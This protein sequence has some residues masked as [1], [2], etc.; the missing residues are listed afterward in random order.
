MNKS[1]FKSR[2]MDIH[3]NNYNNKRYKPF[4]YYVIILAA[5]I[6]SLLLVWNA[7]SASDCKL[8]LLELNNL[9]ATTTSYH[10]SSQ[11]YNL[12]QNLSECNLNATTIPNSYEKRNEVDLPRGIVS[13]TSDLQMQPLWGPRI[14]K[15]PKVQKN[16]LAMA[17]GIK[18]KKNVNTIVNKFL[19]SNFVVM[20]FH[21]DGNVN[22]W[23][24]FE[25]CDQAIHVSA[26]H[27]TK[28]LIL[29]FAK[30]FMH[31][32]ILSDYAYIFLWD[33]DLGVKHF[34]VK[35]YLSI[36]REEGLEISQPALD[37]TKST[38][39]HHQI[40]ERVK[41]QRVHRKVYKTIGQ[42]KCDEN[43][44]KPPCTGWVEMMAPVF[45]IASWRC[46]WHLIQGDRTKNV[47][48][49]DSE[50]LIHYGLPT[51]GD[52]AAPHKVEAKTK[53]PSPEQH[54]IRYEVRKLS[55]AELDIFKNRWRKAVAEDEAWNRAHQDPPQNIT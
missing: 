24:N 33:E 3:N 16:L 11:V 41:E 19:K 18:L 6:S 48:V 38:E 15:N 47:G 34:N 7:K 14:K 13:K 45:T 44:T 32:D 12:K 53:A 26:L 8:S 49:I 52:A 28:C 50:Y 46:V 51:L 20:L 39:I 54:D 30:R 4:Y 2:R 43:S 10:N 5:V 55:F 40:T 1:T 9:N 23:R 25:W 35:R 17:V 42:W 31:P 36:V 27:Q 22:Q 37:P 29:W 21:Y